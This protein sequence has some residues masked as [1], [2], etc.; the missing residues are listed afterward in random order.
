MGFY[1]KLDFHDMEW[2]S[3]EHHPTDPTDAP[4]GKELIPD[5]ACN[6]HIVIPKLTPPSLL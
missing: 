4:L 3:P 2:D 5:Q 6:G 1:R